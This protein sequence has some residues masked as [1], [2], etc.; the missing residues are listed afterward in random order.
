MYTT[1]IAKSYNTDEQTHE[2]IK[3]SLGVSVI[4][5]YKKYLDLPS[6][7]GRDKKAYFVN[8]KEHIWAR[9]Q[10]WKEKL[11]S[12]AGKEVMIKAVI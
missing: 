2:A 1:F 12:Q 7:I 10:G 5:H 6:F 4:Q 9:M 11:L 8:M 3:M